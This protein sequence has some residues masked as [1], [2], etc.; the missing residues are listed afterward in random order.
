MTVRNSVPVPNQQAGLIKSP[1]PEPAGMQR[2]RQ[3]HID[4]VDI[5]KTGKGR[6]EEFTERPG[7]L[8][9]ALV[10]KAMNELRDDS[11]IYQRGPGDSEFLTGT[12]AGTTIVILILPAVK[13][14]A[15]A[16]AKRRFNR[17]QLGQAI[18]A[19]TSCQRYRRLRLNR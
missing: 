10:F 13:R 4:S 16:D 17:C 3:D 2:Y 15:A 14:Q 12:Q 7:Q 11:V 6:Q 19:Q 8:N 5:P 18:W 9:F 1:P